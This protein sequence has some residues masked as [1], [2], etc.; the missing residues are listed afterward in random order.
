MKK[1]EAELGHLTWVYNSHPE[2]AANVG[3]WA[4]YVKKKGKVEAL[5]LT[6]NDLQTQTDRA[7][8]NDEDMPKLKRNIIT[9]VLSK[10]K[11]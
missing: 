1:K 5:M 7:G 4:V 2:N 6:E 11:R 9:W 3:Y 10:I 8:R